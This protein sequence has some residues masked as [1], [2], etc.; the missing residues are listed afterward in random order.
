MR[1]RRVAAHGL[2]LLALWGCAQRPSAPPAPASSTASIDGRYAGLANGSCG[3]N[4]QAEAEIRAGRFRL[5]VPPALALS[6]AAQPDGTLNA[7]QLDGS[8]RQ[9]NFTGHVDGPEMR[10]GSYNGRCG[11]AFTLRRIHDATPRP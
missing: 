7:G 4:Q 11:Y 9:V 1:R 5:S 8:G 10:G 2:A 3:V 6:G